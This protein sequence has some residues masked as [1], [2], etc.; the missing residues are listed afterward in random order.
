MDSKFEN[1]PTPHFSIDILSHNTYTIF[2]NLKFENITSLDP[3]TFYG[4][5]LF[6]RHSVL[7]IGRH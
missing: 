2:V 3:H 1:F 7:D 6:V 5:T 4:D